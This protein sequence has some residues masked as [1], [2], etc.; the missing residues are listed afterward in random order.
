MTSSGAPLSRPLTT[1][2]GAFA[3]SIRGASCH[4]SYPEGTTI[5]E[6]HHGLQLQDKISTFIFFCLYL[7]V[8]DYFRFFRGPQDT[9]CSHIIAFLLMCVFLYILCVCF[10][11]YATPC[12]DNAS[13]NVPLIGHIE[14]SVYLYDQAVRAG[15]PLL[16]CLP[17]LPCIHRPLR[18]MHSHPERCRW[19][20]P[21]SHIGAL[22]VR[23]PSFMPLWG[24]CSGA[25]V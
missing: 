16:P 7:F 1:F 17:S 6:N 24:G 5:C 12:R 8:D 19:Q 2:P 14:A 11:P 15:P 23:Q 9:I 4:Q 20:R 18:Y 22:H 13:S 21:G 25:T 3:T 10:V